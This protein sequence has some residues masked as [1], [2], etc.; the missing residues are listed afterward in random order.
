[1][2]YCVPYCVF[3]C[4]PCLSPSRKWKGVNNKWRL[5]YQCLNNNHHWM[6]IK[7]MKQIQTITNLV[8]GCQQKTRCAFFT[9]SVCRKCSCCYITFLRFGFC[10]YR[11]YSSFWPQPGPEA[12]HYQTQTDIIILLTICNYGVL[13]FPVFLVYFQCLFFNTVAQPVLSLSILHT[14]RIQ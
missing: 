13:Q 2:A 6:L 14:W 10:H 12:K 9:R 4:G 3:G 5:L 7:I 8:H 11:P 1:M